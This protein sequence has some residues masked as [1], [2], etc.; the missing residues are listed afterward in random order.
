MPGRAVLCK[1]SVGN[2]RMGHTM[3]RG[4]T[5]QLTT[6]LKAIW[7]QI[8][9]SRKT[10]CS[11]SYLTLHRIGYIMT[12]SPIANNV[13]GHLGKIRQ[14]HDIPIGTD[15]PTNFPFCSAGPV[16]GTKLPRMMPIAIAKRIHT[17]RKRSSHPK[18]LNAE[19]FSPVRSMVGS[20]RGVW[21]SRSGSID[22]VGA[23]SE[24]DCSLLARTG[25]GCWWLTDP[26]LV[27]LGAV[28]RDVC[29]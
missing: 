9:R 28:D 21:C 7:I 3:T 13:S 27:T 26:I 1:Y 2:G 4:A 22:E 11:V 12:S 29:R 5:I 16:L 23:R 25:D 10:W 14:Q 17:A 15:T 20:L 8:L 6:M 19:V 24:A 18:L